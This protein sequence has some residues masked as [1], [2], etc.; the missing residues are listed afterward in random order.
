MSETIG[1]LEVRDRWDYAD[2]FWRYGEKPDGKGGTRYWV[3]WC[4]HT[5]YGVYGHCWDHMGAPLPKFVSRIDSGYLL[6]K[7]ARKVHSDDVLKASVVKAIRERRRDNE[8]SKERAREA[9]RRLRDLSLDYSGPAL[10]QA[11]YDDDTVSEV[12]GD[13]DGIC[14]TETDPQ[15]VGFVAKFWPMFVAH[16]NQKEP[17]H[18]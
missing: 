7:I 1:H 13:W 5:S 18:V 6:G 8:A 11:L 4:A 16:L 12:L 14:D 3:T 15:A 17:A 9:I 2:F 10:T